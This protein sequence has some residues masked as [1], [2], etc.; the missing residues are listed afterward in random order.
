MN[1]AAKPRK[2]RL[3]DIAGSKNIRISRLAFEEPRLILAHKERFTDAVIRAANQALKQNAE[4]AH[5]G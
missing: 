2:L 1:T 3:F 5:W 4:E